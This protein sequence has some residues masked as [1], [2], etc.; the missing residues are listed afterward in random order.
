MYVHT[1]GCLEQRFAGSEVRRGHDHVE[2]AP[3][4]EGGQL[5]AS[6]KGRP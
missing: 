4:E 6:E 2:E 3:D 5:Q 1:T